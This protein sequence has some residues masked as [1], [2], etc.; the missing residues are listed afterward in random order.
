MTGRVA[1]RRQP[2][3]GEFAELGRRLAGPGGLTRRAS[4][5]DRRGAIQVRS[6]DR[7]SKA[8]VFR[9]DALGRRTFAGFAATGAAGSE[10][11]ASTADFTWDDGNRLVVAADSAGGTYTQAY[12]GYD[13]LTGEQGPHG[14]VGY[15]YDVAGR[16]SSMTVPGQTPTGYSYDAAG[17][18]TGVTR[19]SQNVSVAYDQA[20]RR[21]TTTLPNGV[22]QAYSFDTASRLTG[23]D[24]ALGSSTL[25]GLRYDY[26]A[27]GRRVAQ[28][29]SFARTGLPEPLGSATYDAA[30]RRTAQDG[31]ALSYDAEGN[32]TASGGTTYEWDERGQL[33]TIGGLAGPASF[34]YDAFGRRA[35]KTVG[36]ERTDYVHD[37]DQVVQERR[38]AG[39]ADLLTGLRLDE[40]YARDGAG[41]SASLLTDALGST[42]A[43]T[44]FFGAATTSYTYDPFGNTTQAGAPSDNP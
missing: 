23:I 41:G 6:T 19:R 7:R 8:H 34:S 37:G 4:T 16:R 14:V 12:D 5:F 22:K 27:A 2:R 3:R 38:A 26:D 29:G 43:L 11:F 24:Y 15:S 20:G 10:S 40:V 42:V 31:Q 30:N 9:Y 33:A 21:A 35:A 32:L 13:Q 28:R 36:G 44:D 25:S 18:L 17:R 1:E 39:N